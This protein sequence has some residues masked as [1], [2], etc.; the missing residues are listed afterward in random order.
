MI[1]GGTAGAVAA[2]HGDLFGFIKRQ[3]NGFSHPPTS[4]PSGS[5]FATVGSG[6]YDFW[7]VSLHALATHPIG[8][9]GQDNFA[10]Y[11]VT[12]RHTDEDPAWTHSFE[13]RL[14]AHTGLMGFALFAVFIVAALV[15]AAAARRRGPPLVQVAAGCALLPLV[16]WLIHGSVDWFWEI[17]ALSGPALGFLG[18]AAALGQ[19]HGAAIDLRTR[20]APARRLR[21]AAGVVA[22]VVLVVVLGLPYLAVRKVSAASDLRQRNPRAAL[23]DL[24]DA[25]SLNPLTSDPGVLGGTIALQIGDPTTAQA[26]FR[27]AID[28]EPHGWFAWLGEGLAASVLGDTAQA[29]HDFRLA[30]SLNYKQPAVRAALARVN[31]VH[32]LTPAQALKLLVLAH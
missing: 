19:P 23:S 20:T 21:A 31:T 10:D 17:P 18:M 12:R 1:A 13:M 4:T 24:A 22:L 14:L 2:T 6:R 30:A 29:E 25:A 7:R 26:R 32:P 28:R 27:Q 16:V 11:Y 9:L 3:W 8:G 15:A 5:H